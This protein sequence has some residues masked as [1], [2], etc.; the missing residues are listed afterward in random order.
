MSIKL[1]TVCSDSHN[2]L[3]EKHLLPS[4]PQTLTPVVVKL[5]QRGTGNH[6]WTSDFIAA[7]REKMSVVLHYTMTEKTPFVYCDADIRFNP[8]LDPV[9]TLINMLEENNL[10]IV[11]QR[12]GDEMCAGFMLLDSSEKNANYLKAVLQYMDANLSK[13]DQLAFKELY[14]SNLYPSESKP[15]IGLLDIKTGFGNTNHLQPNVLWS[16]ENDLLERHKDI[17][18]RQ[19]MWHANHTIGVDNKMNML[20]RFKLIC[21]E[22]INNITNK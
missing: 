1:I 21:E 6:G 7:M 17:V 12:D 11:C 8:M 19:F 22:T 5:K 15:R 9:P 14:R 10:D 18:G 4:L 2:E 16:L 3:L 20:N 13:C